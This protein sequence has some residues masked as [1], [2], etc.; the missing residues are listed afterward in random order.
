MTTRIEGIDSTGRGLRARRI[1]FDD[2][3]ERLTSRSAVKALGLEFDMS[4][5][6]AELERSL[7]DVE[8]TL[9]RER[10]LRLLGYRERSVAELARSLEDDGF[11][12]VVTTPIVTSLQASGLVD[13]ERFAE[14]FVRTKLSAG[15]GARRILQELAERGVD[16]DLAEATLAAAGPAEHEVERVR[17]LVQAHP[18]R[19]RRERERLLRKLVAKGF[20]AGTVLDVLRQT[21]SE[22]S[23]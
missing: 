9:A 22:S 14:H 20:A 1:R 23:P 15:L 3:T 17:A 19:D 21:D 13:D 2:G 12:R 10:A 6:P 11:P 16:K 4:L 5:S 7:A 8:P 18:P